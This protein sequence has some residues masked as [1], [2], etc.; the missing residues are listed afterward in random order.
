LRS[1]RKGMPITGHVYVG[2]DP[3]KHRPE[4]RDYPFLCGRLEDVRGALIAPFD[5]FL[6]ATSLDHFQD[7]SIAAQTIRNLARPGALAIFWVGLHDQTFVSEQLGSKLLRGL[8]SSL[9]PLRFFKQLLNI[10]AKFLANYLFFLRRREKIQLNIPLDKLHFHYFTQK[11]LEE[12]LL[13][14]GTVEHQIH[15]PGT[16]SVFVCVRVR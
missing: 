11:T 2:L 6:F 8:Y 1:L 9:H 16:N 5:I 10:Q 3:I 12:A 14:F 7:I 4:A 15:I 13:L